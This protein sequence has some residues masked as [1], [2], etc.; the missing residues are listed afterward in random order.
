MLHDW[1][2]R[3]KNGGRV[4][5]REAWGLVWLAYLDDDES[6]AYA[7]W[8]RNSGVECQHSVSSNIKKKCGL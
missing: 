5:E 8:I 1:E 3:T 7:F 4:E 2:I 6:V